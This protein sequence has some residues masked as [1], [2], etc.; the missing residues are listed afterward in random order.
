MTRKRIDMRNFETAIDKTIREAQER[1]AGEIMITS[2]D[3]DGWLQG[4]DLD[5]CRAVA[6]AVTVPVLILGGCGSWR[7][8]TEGFKDGNA[9][10]VCTQNIY[11]FT[12]TSIQS[13]KLHLGKQGVEVRV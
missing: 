13:A 7:H 12:D 2:I 6:D 4:Y 9:S 8:M 10:A 5:L 3:R 1:G 11:H